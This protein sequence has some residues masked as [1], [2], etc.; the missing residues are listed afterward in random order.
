[1]FGRIAE[2]YDLANRALSLGLDTLWRDRL[3]EEVWI[4]Q[5]N[6]VADLATGSGDVAFALRDSLP[7]EA[8]V[9]GLDFCEPM[10]DQARRKQSKLGYANLSFE[11]GDILQ[12]PLPDAACDAVT[13]AFGYRNLADRARGLAE[14]RRILNPGTGHVFILEFSQPHPL[15]RPFYYFYLKTLL[16][17]LAG[18]LTGDVAAYRYLCDSIES[19]PDRAGV[20]TEL[21]QAGFEEVRAIPLALGAVALH[22]ARAPARC[23]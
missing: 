15:F 17:T 7:A 2:R 6:S 16:P 23:P 11:Q 20:S 22:I 3:V 18:A 13:I 19:F 21:L 8:R 12:L 4:R 14:M 9:A 5:P 1:M 10:L